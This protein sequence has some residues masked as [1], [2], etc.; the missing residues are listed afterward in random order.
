MYHWGED[1]F[2]V[3]TIQPILLYN[4]PNSPGVTND[5]AASERFLTKLNISEIY[6]DFLSPAK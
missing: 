6:T 5:L 4:F 3:G 1:D 2:E